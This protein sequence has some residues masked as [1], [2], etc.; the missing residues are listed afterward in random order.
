[1][2]VTLRKP[3]LGSQQLAAWFDSTPYHASKTQTKEHAMKRCAWCVNPDSDYDPMDPER[4][5]CRS[6]WAEYEGLS[7][8][9]LDHM[10]SEQAKDFA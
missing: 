5:L 10:M 7:L 8:D 9:G 6:H 3:R 4:E 2:R 1:V